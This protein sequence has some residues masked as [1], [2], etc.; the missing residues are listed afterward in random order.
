MALWSHL[1]GTTVTQRKAALGMTKAERLRARV[2]AQRVL[3]RVKEGEEKSGTSPDSA[4][5]ESETRS[6][7]HEDVGGRSSHRDVDLDDEGEDAEVGTPADAS[8]TISS[9]ITSSVA[10]NAFS[11]VRRRREDDASVSG[12]G[13]GGGSR[14]SVAPVAEGGLRQP[15]LSI[16]PAT[17]RFGT[18]ARGSTCIAEV[19]VQNVSVNPVKFRLLGMSSGHKKKG[20]SVLATTEVCAYALFP[21]ISSF[22]YPFLLS[23]LSEELM[24]EATCTLTVELLAREVGLVTKPVQIMTGTGAQSLPVIARIV[25]PHM[26]KPAGVGKGVRVIQ[27]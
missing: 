22:S 16:S 1:P 25:E 15:A 8:S 11:A 20:N 7:P 19:E 21:L 3:E 17:V 27:A 26:W 6:R 9:P 23:Q 24:P 2:E 12:G 18:I 10:G 14:R 13:G 4:S 5:P